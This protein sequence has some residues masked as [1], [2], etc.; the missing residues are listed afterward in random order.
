[1]PDPLELGYAQLRELILSG[2]RL[3]PVRLRKWG[4]QA[5]DQD[6]EHAAAD[7]LAQQHEDAL[8]AYL[9]IFSQRRFP[10]DPGPLLGLVHHRSRRVGSAATRA[11]EQITDPRVR[12]LGLAILDEPSA[13]G[14]LLGRGVDLLV[15]NFEPADAARLVERLGR[16]AWGQD[17]DG[18]HNLGFA[19]LDL[20]KAHPSSDGAPALLTLYEHGPC[21]ICRERC[22]EALQALDQLPEWMPAECRYDANLALRERFSN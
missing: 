11:L 20:L 9:R 6:L 13:D 10:L 22:V 8:V 15:N 1:V 19:T 5:S 2:A 16:R 4:Q 7:L 3:G 21:S 17:R 14:D 12:A 18:D